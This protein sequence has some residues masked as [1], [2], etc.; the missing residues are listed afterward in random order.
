MPK[1]LLEKAKSIK[2]AHKG[3]SKHGFDITLQDEEL[4][5]AW[6]N[7][8]IQVKQLCEA[9]N[10]FYGSTSAYNYIAQVARHIFSS[11]NASGKRS[12]K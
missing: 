9:K 2:T 3:N 8:E 6:L 1:T 7:R 12:K 5:W 10:M 4:V 11:S